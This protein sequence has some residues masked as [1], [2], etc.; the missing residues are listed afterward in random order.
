MCNKS[1][2]IQINYSAMG[3]INFKLEV[4][5][6]YRSKQPLYLQLAGNSGKDMD[7]HH[8]VHFAH[9]KKII[10]LVKI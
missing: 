7:K 6:H 5:K 3:P 9:Q 1:T 2:H 4:M 10:K 8:W